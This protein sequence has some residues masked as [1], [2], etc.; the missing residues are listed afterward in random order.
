MSTLC[1]V[2]FANNRLPAADPDGEAGVLE[3]S[4]S[5]RIVLKTAYAKEDRAVNLEADSKLRA[6]SA[7]GALTVTTDHIESR[8][9]GQQSDDTNVAPV[10]THHSIC[11]NQAEGYKIEEHYPPVELHSR[12]VV[13]CFCQRPDPMDL[14]ANSW[15]RHSR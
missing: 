5:K 11:G 1:V 15:P 8:H 9:D 4:S 14:Q 13:S 12:Y 6:A 3:E 2:E 7:R 10:W